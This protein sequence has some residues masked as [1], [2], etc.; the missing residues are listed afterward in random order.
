MFS[1]DFGE[2][3]KNIFPTAHLRK[4]VF[5]F[6][7]TIFL[8]GGFLISPNKLE[9]SKN[10]KLWINLYFAKIRCYKMFCNHISHKQPTEVFFL[11][12][13]FLSLS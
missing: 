5:V 8:K 12:K 4:S 9:H 13:F 1:C 6:L 3:V 7:Q 11:V 10:K 2:I